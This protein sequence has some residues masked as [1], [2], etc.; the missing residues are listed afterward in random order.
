MTPILWT[1]SY[2]WQ[3]C[4]R[5]TKP[6]QLDGLPLLVL[7]K[8]VI[9]HLWT[10]CTNHRAIWVLCNMHKSADKMYSKLVTVEM[11]LGWEFQWI[12]WHSFLGLHTIESSSMSITFLLW[13]PCYIWWMYH[14]MTRLCGKIRYV[15]ERLY[16]WSD[17]QVH[18]WDLDVK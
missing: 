8:V 18:L 1:M 13:I 2:E 12:I 15:H 9:F 4:V 6:H 17:I 7:I 3:Y 14:I 10:V 5:Q 11:F 16:N